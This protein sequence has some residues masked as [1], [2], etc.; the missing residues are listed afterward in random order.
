MGY[1]SA[2]RIWRHTC[3]ILAARI[4]FIGPSGEAALCPEKCVAFN[5]E[6]MTVSRQLFVPQCNLFLAA[7]LSEPDLLTKRALT[8]TDDEV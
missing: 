4:Y 1:A 6:W 5:W 3:E 7:G 8:N 2:D